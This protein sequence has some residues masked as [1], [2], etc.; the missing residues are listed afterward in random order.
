MFKI[1]ITIFVFLNSFIVSA[2]E[3]SY[4]DLSMIP[5]LHEGRIKPLDTFARVHLLAIYGKSTIKNKTKNISANVWMWETIFEPEVAFDRRVF[6]IRNTEVVEALSLDLNQSHFY[7]FNEISVA[8]RAN[9]E[10]ISK[11]RQISRKS[12][13]PAQRQI[14]DLY[15]KTL[16]YYEIARS[17]SLVEKRF[18]LRSETNQKLLGVNHILFSYKDIIGKLDVLSKKVDD[19][20]SSNKDKMNSDEQELISLYDEVSRIGMDDRTTVFRIIPPQFKH[21]GDNWFSPWQAL[22]VGAGTPK[23]VEFYR[24]FS[25]LGPAYKIRDYKLFNDTAKSLKTLSFEMA[26]D[27]VNETILG[28]EI[29]YNKFELFY[30]AIAL[31]IFSFLLLSASFLFLKSRMQK[32]AFISLVT[33][34]SLHAAGLVL[35]CVIMNRPPV[36]TLYESTLFVG[37]IAVLFAVILEIVKK[38]GMGTFIGSILGTVL[39]FLSF[40]YLTDGDSMGMLAAVL[41]TNFWL[42]THVVTI[43]I[44]Y[45]CCFVAGILSHVYLVQ[46]YLETKNGK[47]FNTKELAR[48]ILGAALVALFFSV[49]GTILGGI[50]ADQSWGRFWGWD[51]KENGAMLICLWLLFLIHGKISGV[52]KDTGFAVG[53]VITNTVV[54]LAWFGVNLLAVGLHSYGFTENIALNLLYFCSSEVLFAV[55]FGVLIMINK[56]DQRKKTA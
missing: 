19:Y 44:G 9:F 39:L 56:N 26:N 34:F 30:S 22:N 3:F 42:A 47:L 21:S 53:M 13:T 52:L 18:I 54:A 16:R 11:L 10:S 1:L 38:G 35:R 33:G 40:G 24:L 36:T 46:K 51:P 28:L 43:T 7:T 45:G 6:D 48:N 55:I 2:S 32:A 4:S 14:L 12:Q 27:R 23:T 15:M 8:L 50:W 31:Y 37:A 20:K 49:L 25:I 29:K 17:F 41:D 5:V